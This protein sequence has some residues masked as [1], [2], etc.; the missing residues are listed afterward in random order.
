[1][2]KRRPKAGKPD[3]PEEAAALLDSQKVKG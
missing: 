2:S 1:M 3:N